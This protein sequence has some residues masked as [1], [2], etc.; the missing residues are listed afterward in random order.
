M[1]HV[2]VSKQRVPVRVLRLVAVVVSVPVAVPMTVAVPVS[3][4]PASPHLLELFAARHRQ[5]RRR[6]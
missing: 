3:A 5:R 4:A 6:S 1:V 2:D